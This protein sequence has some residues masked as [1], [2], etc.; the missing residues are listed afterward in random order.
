MPEVRS[1]DPAV[2]AYERDPRLVHLDTEV[3]AS[4]VDGDRPFVMLADTVLYPEGGGQPADTGSVG[5]VAVTD[6]QRVEGKIRHYLA[7]PVPSGSVRVQLD[8]ARRFDH[9]QQ[10]TGQHLLTAVAAERFGWNTT[11]FHL[12]PSISDIELDH[13]DL[14]P[15]GLARLE[16]AVAAEVRAA[17][18]VT[19]RRVDAG[20][21]ATLPVRSR[22]LPGGHT[23]SIRLVE[24]EGIDLNTCGGTHC[25]STAELE[26]VKL[27]GTESMRGGTRLFYAAGARLRRIHATHHE[28]NARLRTLLGT[29]DDGLVSG[30]EGKLL[31][32][33]E[34]QRSLRSIEEELA[35]VSARLLVSG[36]GA[37][38]VGHWP[39][40]TLPFLQRV[41]RELGLLAPERVALL[42][43]G[44][45]EDGAF[46]VAAGEGAPLEAPA[47]GPA[48]GELLSGRG[49]GAGRIY[50]GK[51]AT[52]SRRDEAA[53]LLAGML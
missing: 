11:A 51:A 5:G 6:V 33:K 34:L 31:Q 52:L 18:A 40:R 30:V 17:R 43:C 44:D 45:G 48:V 53:A 27:L 21:Y 35:V 4:G 26:A 46:V 14:G 32:L 20:V 29:S 16:E 10:H 22:G 49:G 23:G 7:G 13:A 47:V 9:M 42:T 3:L 37:L 39:E 19:T 41:A 12:G 25:A 24:I 8:W 28:R 50:Q 36:A 2:P 38:V 1:S 15:D